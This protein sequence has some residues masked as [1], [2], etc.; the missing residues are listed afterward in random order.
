MAKL[1]D[2]SDTRGISLEEVI[3]EA[4]Y[5]YVNLSDPEMKSEMHLNLCEKYSRDAEEL[6]S[7][8]DYV[9]AGEKLWG[10]AAQALKAVAARRGITLDTHAKLWNFVA[11]LRTELDD[12]EIGRLWSIANALHKNFY[13]VQIS[14]ELV[15]DYAQDV[16]KLV[17]KLKRLI[18]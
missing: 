15:K 11:K 17:D 18:K 14:P 3:L 16:K 2:L 5:E 12:P 7:K 1:R 8:G 10:A 9:Q 6:L 13:E 4:I